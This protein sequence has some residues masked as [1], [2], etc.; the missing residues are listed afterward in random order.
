M[1][2]DLFKATDRAVRRADSRDPFV[3][4]GFLSIPISDLILDI[5]GMTS[6]FG[7]QAVIGINVLFMALTGVLIYRMLV[8]YLHV[9]IILIIV[10]CG[11]L[12]ALDTWYLTRKGGGKDK[13]E[14]G[15]RG[16][17]GGGARSASGASSRRAR[18]RPHR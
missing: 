10:F 15:G 17:G 8:R 12:G 1:T 3:V 16:G 6:L 13:G 5:V 4:A 2:S 9:N 18:P 14:A 11:L 7:H